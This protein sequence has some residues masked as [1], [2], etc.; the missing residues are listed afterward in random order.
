MPAILIYS[1]MKEAHALIAAHAENSARLRAEFFTR[2]ADVICEAAFQTALAIARGG[3]LLLCGNGGSAA[4]CQ[5]VA[6]EFVNRFLI[7]RPGLP[8]IALT[9]D[10]SIITAIGNDISFEA[11]F[12]RQVEA[13]GRPGDML[14]AIS[15]SGNSPD[16]LAA[17][18]AARKK[19]MLVTGLTGQGGAMAALCDYHI[20]VP[21]QSTPLIQEM[22]LACEHIFCQLC[23]YFLFE[24]PAALAA[25]LRDE[26]ATL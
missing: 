21:A 4:D 22:H 24:N 10:S 26:N 23:D 3:K 16:V 18:D 25:A 19:E 13:L 6:G 11:I 7:D 2:R 1:A 8:A 14:L 20:A 15:T 5:H 12:S 9:T 17:I